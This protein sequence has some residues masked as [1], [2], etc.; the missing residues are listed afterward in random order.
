[1]VEL[2]PIGTGK[3]RVARRLDTRGASILALGDDRTDAELFAALPDDALRVQVGAGPR[4]ADL[5]LPDPRAARTLLWRLL[6]ARR[7]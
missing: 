6:Q 5:R 1:V 4:I 3:A 2:R 7:P